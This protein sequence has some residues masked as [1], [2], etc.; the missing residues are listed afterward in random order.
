MHKSRN[1]YDRGG[2]NEIN[3]DTKDCRQAKV[4]IREEKPETLCR[5]VIL[6][7]LSSQESKTLGNL[8]T[9][10]PEVNYHKHKSY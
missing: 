9:G 2:K 10:H 8:I 1:T 4:L 7:Q 3:V 6:L 5:A